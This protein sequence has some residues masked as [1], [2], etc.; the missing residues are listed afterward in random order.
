MCRRMAA[1]LAMGLVL[2]GAAPPPATQSRPSGLSD[3]QA[4]ALAEATVKKTVPQAVLTPLRSTNMHLG[5]VTP[6]A[7]PLKTCVFRSALLGQGLAAPR[8]AFVCVS[9]DGKVQYPFDA[10]KQFGALLAAEDVA[11]WREAQFLTAAILY[12][13][14]TSVANEDGWKVLAKPEDFMAITFNMPTQGPAV[15]KRAEAANAIATP[16]VIS[17]DDT[18]TVKFFA[19]HLI[20]GVLREWT[21]TFGKDFSASFRDVG[22]W[23]GGGYD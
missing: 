20:G 12:V 21:V 11:N 14:L 23:G 4:A 8:R 2:A 22:R 18:V 7:N 17:T 19:W 15:E 3:D 10:A 9:R 6:V 5:G 13:H 16:K 1:M